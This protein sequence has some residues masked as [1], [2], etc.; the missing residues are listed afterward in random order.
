MLVL[1]DCPQRLTGLLPLAERWSRWSASNLP[2][3]DRAL[4]RALGSGDEVAV[5]EAG[6][7]GADGFWSRLLVVAEAPLSQFDVLRSLLAGGIVLPGAVASLALH[8]RNFRGHHGREWR[9]APGN[10]H[11]CAAWRPEALAARDATALTMLPALA[12]ARAVRLASAGG[13]RPGIKWVNDILVEGHKVGGVLTAAVSE[14]QRVTQV[15]VG[16]GLNLSAAPPVPPTPFVP[17]VA[18]L[19][20]LGL[21]LPAPAAAVFVLE[22]IAETSRRLRDEGP[23]PI[24]LGYR[25]ASLVTGREVCVW[26][27]D[28]DARQPLAAWPAPLARGVV[29]EITPDLALRIVESPSLIT[30]GRLAFAEHCR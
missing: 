19:A 16:I 5:A 28:L 30:A 17:S 13:L 26:P 2:E 27:A 18:C 8:G 20:D 4:W 10:L 15:V 11:L 7:P 14:R 9:A 23:L 25:L 22:E 12:A 1:T 29:R 24:L 6:P 3:P 21:E